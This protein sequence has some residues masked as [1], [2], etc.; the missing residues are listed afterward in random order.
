MPEA[1]PEQTAALQFP[2]LRDEGCD[3]ARPRAPGDMKARYRIAMA[4]GKPAAAFG[5]ADDRKP[6]HALRMQPRALLARPEI[7]I[8]LRPGARP[9]ILLAVEAGGR[10]PVLQGQLAAVADAHPPLLGRVDEEQAAERPEGLAAER[11]LRLLVEEDDAFAGIGNFG[12]CGQS[13]EPRPDDDDIGLMIPH[14]LG[15][16]VA[17]DEMRPL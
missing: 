10:H 15:L 16:P 14:A 12:C 11:L 5:P 4:V 3:D 1:E 6:A 17:P 8:A 2:R 7:D 13:G 9:M